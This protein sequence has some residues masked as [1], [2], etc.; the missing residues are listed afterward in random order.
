MA[1]RYKD[2][3]NFVRPSEAIGFK[4][5]DREYEISGKIP[6]QPMLEALAMEDEEGGSDV[7]TV[8]RLLKDILGP[9]NYNTLMADLDLRHAE[10]VLQG[11]IE[12]V[13]DDFSEQAEE[14]TLEGVDGGKAA[15][16]RKQ[17]RSRQST[18]SS[19]GTNSKPT[20]GGIM[21]SGVRISED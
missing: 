18:S 10:V 8:L 9:D 7:Q 15:K 20:S 17:L 13:M 2:F 19:T 1:R 4:Y 3:N 6:F 21:L 14:G 11:L 16:L 5:G 12:M